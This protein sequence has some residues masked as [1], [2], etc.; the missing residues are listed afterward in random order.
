MM[1][2]IYY[3]I[4]SYVILFVYTRSESSASMFVSYGDHFIFGRVCFFSLAF[5]VN[6]H[7]RVRSTIELYALFVLGR[8]KKVVFGITGKE[9]NQEELICVI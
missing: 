1:M 6:Y 9:G 2:D 8:K 4:C 5:Q 3:T 7:R